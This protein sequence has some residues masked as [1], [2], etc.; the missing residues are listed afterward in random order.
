MIATKIKELKPVLSFHYNTYKMF[1]KAIIVEDLDPIILSTTE[2]LKN[3]SIGEIQ[4]A[5]YCDDAFLKIKKAQHENKPF[6]LLI[7]D[8]S[9]K[10]DHRENK[11]KNGEQLISEIKKNQPDI[12]IIVFSIEDKSF[13]IKSL[14][15]DLKI[16]AYVIKGRNSIEE[17]KKAIET[18]YH[19]NE[20]QFLFPETTAN[21][22]H[23]KSVIEIEAY[24][25]ELLKSLSKGCS[26]NEI[27]NEF[28]ISGIHP[29]GNSSIEKRLNKLKMYFKA[30]NNVHL[31]AITK[32]MG[33]I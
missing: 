1:K 5:K 22:T 23:K 14:F 2:T 26:I 18:T 30:N 3:L 21:S 19:N 4:T 16:N 24:D 9:F 25:I 32:D 28:K 33:L 7:T 31:I 12:K 15:E 29:S 8:L 10:E 27:A 13:K 11:L 20:A 17:L 6:D